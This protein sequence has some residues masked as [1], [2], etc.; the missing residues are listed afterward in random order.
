[1]KNLI[2]TYNKTS[3]AGVNTSSF[4]VFMNGCNLVCPYC[5]NSKLICNGGNPD[6]TVLAR[7]KEDF[8]SYQPEMIMISGGEPTESPLELY[9]IIGLFE[10]WGC[11]VG[12]S[13]NGTNPDILEDLVKEH[14][15]VDYVAMDLKG[16][17]IIY[18]CL[19]DY[20]YFMK[21]LSSWLILREE[22]RTRHDFN[23]EIRTTL[24]PPFITDNRLLRMAKLFKGEE[25]WVLQQ[26]RIAP[27]MPNAKNVEPYS[28][29]MLSYLFNMVKN[30]VPNTVIRYI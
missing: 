21:V 26:F 2:Y 6:P 7:L 4:S 20:E 23:Y 27:S 1:M 16:D 24:Y 22:K 30:L 8:D 28:E 13:T 12:L 18:D 29:E 10:S 25:R 5:M 9:A 17:Q 15:S 3:D 19:G 14:K 11:K